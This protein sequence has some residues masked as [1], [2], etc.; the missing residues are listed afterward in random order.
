MAV[1][2]N[3]E[4]VKP[5]RGTVFD[6]IYKPGETPILSGIYRCIGCGHE[7]VAE[8]SRAFPTQNLHQHTEQQGAIRWQLVVCPNLSVSIQEKGR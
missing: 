5:T 3:S 6:S 7:V 2:Q 4:W 1:Y 8:H